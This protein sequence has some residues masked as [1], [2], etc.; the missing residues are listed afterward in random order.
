MSTADVEL[1]G[2]Q[3]LVDLSGTPGHLAPQLYNASGAGYSGTWGTNSGRP[4]GD[5]GN[6]VEY[7]GTNGDSATFSFTGTGIQVLSETN[8]DEGTIDVYVDG[9][10][11]ETVNAVQR[12]A[13]CPAADR[14]H[15]R[16]ESGLAHGQ[17]GQDR[18]AVH[19]R[20][21]PSR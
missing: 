2:Q 13:R 3:E 10:K 5:L 9:T 20:S 17:A 18:R 8:S 11:A 12:D 7:T 16:S 1:P 6:A 14:R 4:Y 15:Q 19:A 21:M